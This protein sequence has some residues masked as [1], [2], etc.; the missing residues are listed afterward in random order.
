[1]LLNPFWETQ[2]PPFL[3][4]PSLSLCY[5]VRVKSVSGEQSLVWEVFQ[6]LCAPFRSHLPVNP[7][8]C[9]YSQEGRECVWLLNFSGSHSVLKKA[10]RSGNY[11]ATAD[12]PCL[13][14]NMSQRHIWVILCQHHLSF[15]NRGRTMRLW[16]LATRQQG[17]L[18]KKTTTK[19]ECW[20]V[21]NL[22]GKHTIQ[23]ICC[24]KS[25]EMHMICSRQA[26]YKIGAFHLVGRKIC[27]NTSLTLGLFQRRIKYLLRYSHVICVLIW[28]HPAIYKMLQSDSKQNINAF[29]RFMQWWVRL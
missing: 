22:V 26:C 5:S 14:L 15:K 27:T 23:Q 8:Y 1:M 29:V 25:V 21:W 3:S 2:L 19:R 28:W 7:W 6:S 16:Q 10:D 18:Q 9:Q 13:S 12:M 20:P 24:L 11:E 4:Q 17:P